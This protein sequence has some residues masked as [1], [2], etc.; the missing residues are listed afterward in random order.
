MSPFNFDQRLEEIQLALSKV[1][2]SPQNPNVSLLDE[3]DVFYI[4]LSW[5]ESS[6]RDTALAA[7]CAATIKGSR[8]QFERY[9][10]GSTT[11]R[12]EIQKRIGER[13]REAF[14]T[15]DASRKPASVDDACSIELVLDDAIF[16]VGGDDLDYKPTL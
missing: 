13:V 7:R 16:D 3:G 4:H 14:G 6:T 8:A 2:D 11:Q 15:F 9:A 12:L 5:I 10:A 1:F